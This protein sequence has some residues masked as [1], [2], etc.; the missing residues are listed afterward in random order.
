M[1][2]DLDVVYMWHCITYENFETTVPSSDGK[3]SYVVRFDQYHHRNQRDTVCDWSCTCKAYEVGKGKYCK[4]INSVIASGVR[5]G[6]SQFM[7]GGDA[8][9]DAHGVYHCP[10]CHGPVSSMG[11]GV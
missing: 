6:W 10:K 7:G 11:Y 3:S 2:P 4:H 1:M 9:P 5:C 8:M